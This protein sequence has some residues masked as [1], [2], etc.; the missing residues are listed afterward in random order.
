MNTYFFQFKALQI[1]KKKK[2]MFEKTLQALFNHQSEFCC[3]F[4]FKVR[5]G[6]FVF[7]PFVGTGN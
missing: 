3:F 6:S 4:I 1:L 5:P 2:K 7:D